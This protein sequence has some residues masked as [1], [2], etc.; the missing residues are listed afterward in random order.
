[1]NV[2]KQG[3]KLNNACIE[4]MLEQGKT[5]SH[6]QKTASKL[7]YR[8]DEDKRAFLR[9][10]ITSIELREKPEGQSINLSSNM[11]FEDIYAE[12]KDI[13]AIKGQHLSDTANL[14]DFA[15]NSLEGIIETI[16]SDKYLHTFDENDD[17][18]KA[19]ITNCCD[20]L[21][22]INKVITSLL[23]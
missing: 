6:V 18:S 1:M 3:D 5:V 2:Y 7:K 13:S 14:L 16:L 22:K 20:R 4:K 19:V 10:E 9:G 17:D 15:V 8:S 11:S 23:T 12:I 21:N